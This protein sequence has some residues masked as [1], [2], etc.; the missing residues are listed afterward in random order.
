MN[1]V[2]LKKDS[3]LW[4]EDGN[5]VVVAQQTAFR[6]HRSVLSRHSDTFSGLFTLP[7][8]ADPAKIESLDGCP[9]VRVSD[10]SHDFKHLLNVLYDG[11]RYEL[12]ESRNTPEFSTLAALARLG[13]K[14]EMTK[15]FASA[16]KRLSALF[17]T[18]YHIWHENL[19]LATGTV[20]QVDGSET[21]QIG[22]QG[23]HA[24]EQVTGGKTNPIEACN[25][26]RQAEQ[27][28]LLPVA[29]L[30]CTY[31]PV[32]SLLNG[33]LRADGSTERLSPEDLQC[34]IEAIIT[35][36][37]AGTRIIDM[38]LMLSCPRCTGNRLRVLDALDSI[39]NF[40]SFMRKP[41]VIGHVLENVVEQERGN[42]IKCPFCVRLRIE[43]SQEITKSS[44]NK[45]PETF[46]LLDSVQDWPTV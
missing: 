3:E 9:V 20:M 42:G 29:M 5:V 12:L 21:E 1:N 18:D 30:F 22:G 14:Y 41:F 15:I 44:W 37:Q 2:E 19:R 25:L 43:R 7:Q 27:F 46:G 45:L 6:V 16:M 35:F 38:H 8:P 40:L 32:P 17:P 13:H 4:F 33:I 26:F 10:S 39:P 36:T 23:V 28:H 24:L 11:A 31:L 34:C